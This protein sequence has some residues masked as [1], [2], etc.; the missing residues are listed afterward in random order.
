LLSLVKAGAGL[1]TGASTPQGK[2]M[3]TAQQIMA[4]VAGL[5][6]ELRQY[7]TDYALIDSKAAAQEAA[8]KG[9]L[10]VKAL[11]KAIESTSRTPKTPKYEWVTITD[12]DTGKET[13]RRLNTD[14]IGVLMGDS[15][16]FKVIP[17]KASS[18]PVVKS[19]APE[20]NDKEARRL[21][22]IVKDTN[23]LKKP[24]DRAF[25]ASYLQ[26][27]VSQTDHTGAGSGQTTITTYKDYT[28]IFPIIEPFNVKKRL[29]E[30]NILPALPK[31]FN[32]IAGDESSQTQPSIFTPKDREKINTVLEEIKP[33][34]ENAADEFNLYRNLSKTTN[35]LKNELEDKV[36]VPQVLRS[37]SALIP[38]LKAKFD[39]KLGGEM[40]RII[41]NAAT[42]IKE[43]HLGTQLYFFQTDDKGN[44]VRDKDNNLKRRL[45]DQNEPTTLGY[46]GDLFTGKGFTLKGVTNSL[47]AMAASSPKGGLIS[48]V[49]KLFNPA[50]ARA[51]RAL[52]SSV[53]NLLRVRTGAAAPETE[54]VRYALMFMPRPFDPVSVARD[55]VNAMADFWDEALKIAAKGEIGN[56]EDYFRDSKDLVKEMEDLQKDPKQ[57]DYEKK[58]LAL[59]KQ[60]DQKVFGDTHPHKM[61]SIAPLK[62]IMAGLR[63]NTN[64]NKPGNAAEAEKENPQRFNNYPNTPQVGGY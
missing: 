37:G 6:P 22:S 1:A 15:S 43:L 26:D 55:K 33:P 12:V 8:A 53:E 42:G 38:T 59:R 63:L 41:L 56:F 58:Y 47:T 23:Q 57:K 46:V 19:S 35:L 60:Y 13:V 32:W 62:E 25:L 4:Q 29:V 3:S 45:N 5:A 36:T 9:Q 34:S 7:A 16:K 20:R 14:Q 51:F 30:L 61:K 24:S 49:S 17:Y 27:K 48:N 54:V 10:R 31:G 28:P 21:L 64:E 44:L 18:D 39:Q 2:Q 50:A 11:D 52:S 40:K